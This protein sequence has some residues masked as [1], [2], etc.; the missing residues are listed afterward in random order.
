MIQ[1]VNRAGKFMR[2]LKDNELEALK[3]VGEFCKN[4]MDEKV[5]IDTGYLKSRNEYKIASNELFLQND[6]HYAGYVENGTSKM[7]A[8]P[9]MKP[10]VFNH[11]GDIKRITAEY[12]KKGV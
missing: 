2:Q 1:I 7:A 5:P 11:L 12:L 8:Q 6:A 9:F 10:A 3:A 4:K